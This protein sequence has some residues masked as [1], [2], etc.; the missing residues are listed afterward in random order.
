[1]EGKRCD[2]SSWLL[3]YW[4]KFIPP[5]HLWVA[6]SSAVCHFPGKVIPGIGFRRAS[7]R[8]VLFGFGWRILYLWVLKMIGWMLGWLSAVNILAVGTGILLVRVACRLVDA[9]AL[10]QGEKEG[11]EISLMVEV[12]SSSSIPLQVDVIL[13]VV[14]GGFL[15]R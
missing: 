4:L 12:R 10:S 7:E 6:C 13:V 1:M 14:E 15:V 11:S 3:Q 5:F 9:K 8:L 2:S